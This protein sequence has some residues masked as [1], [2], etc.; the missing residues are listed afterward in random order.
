MRVWWN[1]WVILLPILTIGQKKWD[2]GAGTKHWEDPANWYPDGV[3]IKSDSVLLDNSLI[4]NDYRI[5]LPPGNRST[6]IIKMMIQPTKGKTIIA[7]IPTSS[8][9]VPALLLTDP[10]EGLSI[11]A[12][13]VFI[14]SS[15]ASS[16]NPLQLN[17]KLR[18]QNHARYIH[19]TLRGNADITNKLST[20][21]GTELGVVE[22]DIPGTGNYSL[23]LTGKTF[24]SLVFTAPATG[25]KTYQAIGSS[26]CRIRGDLVI[27]KGATVN[28]Q[29]TG[30]MYAEGNIS[31]HG[32]L[33]LNPSSKDSTG[34]SLYITGPSCHW[35]GNGILEM[36][37][38]FRQ[39]IV[40]RLASLTIALP[41][42]LPFESNGIAV[43]GYLHTISQYPIRGAGSFTLLAGG[44]ITI[45]NADG[46]AS[47]GATF[48]IKTN[49]QFFSTHGNYH[50][51]S[52]QLQVTGPNFPDTINKLYLDN[53]AGLVL[54]QPVY[55]RDSLI[56]I[57]G[58]L[59]TDEQRI[60]VDAGKKKSRKKE[61]YINGKVIARLTD[62][63]HKLIPLGRKGK[64]APIFIR[65]SGAINNFDIPLTY[66][67][68]PDPQSGLLYDAWSFNIQDTARKIHIAPIPQASDSL[69]SIGDIQTMIQFE[70]KMELAAT[71]TLSINALVALE[72]MQ[73]FSGVFHVSIRQQQHHLLP[74][75]SIHLDGRVLHAIPKLIIKV[76]GQ[77][78]KLFIQKSLNGLIYSIVD[79]VNVEKS[80]LPIS[81]TDKYPLTSSSFFRI[82]YFN[83]ESPRYSN[84]IKLTPGYIPGT[85]VF[86]NP[87]RDRIFIISSNPC[88]TLNVVLVNTSGA[89]VQVRRSSDNA[90]DIST[91]ATGQYFL[92]IA[93]CG[94]SITL[95]FTKN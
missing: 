34:R 48:P 75:E 35:N 91:L 17:G 21:A 14:N 5:E 36:N 7:E 3:P 33:A 80:A 23:S 61:A 11:E 19:K 49:S 39:F 45:S 27:Q 18:L 90:F 31:I 38:H 77:D 13:G 46:L 78:D 54:H 29:L 57:N 94:Q 81:W 16:G 9:S 71:K 60:N 85:K 84:T 56:L 24:G 47:N 89:I 93:G 82:L 66:S 15:T 72:S 67:T 52:T 10:K 55:I 50:F 69:Y 26:N 1:L 20:V 68:L 79:T 43:H 62:L 4:M 42:N 58:I 87:A 76:N 25:T 65:S 37:A 70:K 53:P 28:S 30:N 6:E 92:Q 83:G 2:G 63:Q 8:T 88:S 32:K 59:F 95:P 86:P 22:F 40:E 51:T 44:G 73:S 12:G 64:P 41:I 74:I